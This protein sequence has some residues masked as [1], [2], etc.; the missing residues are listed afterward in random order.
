M[1]DV[2]PILIKSLVYQN[3]E[4]LDSLENFVQNVVQNSD[5]GNYNSSDKVAIK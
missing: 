2:A 5:N 1:I 3:L 4:P